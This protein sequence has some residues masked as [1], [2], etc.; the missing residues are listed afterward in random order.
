M[1]RSK[2]LFDRSDSLVQRM[3][4]E[5]YGDKKPNGVHHAWPDHYLVYGWIPEQ[6]IVKTFTLAQLQG[7]CERQGIPL[8]ES[9]T[10]IHESC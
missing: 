5:T 1:E 7:A 4:G 9:C 8:G 10:Y 2:V 3:G 6:C